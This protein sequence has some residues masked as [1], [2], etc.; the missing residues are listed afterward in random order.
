MAKKYRATKRWWESGTR[1]HA[2]EVEAFEQYRKGDPQYSPFCYLLYEDENK[3]HKKCKKP[4]KPTLRFLLK[5]ER[6]KKSL[7]KAKDF[8]EF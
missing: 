4:S 2:K 8:G 6:I 1:E 3:E 5:R 7:K